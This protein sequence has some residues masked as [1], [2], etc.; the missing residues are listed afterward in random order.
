MLAT[1]RAI[2][3]LRARYRQCSPMR[4]VLIIIKLFTILSII[5]YIYNV[6]YMLSCV[7]CVYFHEI[8]LRI[9]CL[10]NIL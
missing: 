5:W 6:L 10:Q 9:I 4:K 8:T 3:S 1:A 2:I 7:C